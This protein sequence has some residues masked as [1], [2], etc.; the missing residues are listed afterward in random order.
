MKIVIAEDNR[1]FRRLLEV[2]LT[3]WGHEVV[4]CEDGEAAWELLSMEDS[5]KLAILD[6]EMPKM[7]GV[8]ICRELRKLK[9]KPYVYIILLTAKS[10]KDDLVEGMTAGAD[11]YITKPFEP[12]ELEVRLRAATRIVK[13]Q[14]D[15][16]AAWKAE[17]VRA[18]EDSLTGLW[19][20]SSI[21]QILSQELDRS[22]R[23]GTSLGIIMADIDNFKR[24]NDS[25]GHLEGDRVL[26]R[27]SEVLKSNLRTYDSV[28]RFGGEEFLIVLPS[29]DIRHTEYLAERLLRSVAR[30]KA[31]M[32]GEGETLT[33]SLGASCVRGH[34][35][36]TAKSAIKMADDAL[37]EAKRSGRNRVVMREFLGDLSVS[38]LPSPPLPIPGDRPGRAYC[39]EEVRDDSSRNR[40]SGGGK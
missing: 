20:H 13:L 3:Q 25:Y 6:W 1:F 17:E 10:R 34:T 38:P 22:S 16:L 8:D 40:R 14:E 15:L 33:L 30:D 2:N 31:L 24:I 26:R 35:G 29:C 11:D 7:Q 28:G 12:L 21:I 19:N 39:E 37:Y 32:I 23:N 36:G 18:K 9:D 27:I 5:P 4:Q